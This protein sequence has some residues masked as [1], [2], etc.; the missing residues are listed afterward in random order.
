VAGESCSR[1]CKDGTTAL[2]PPTSGSLSQLLEK[3]TS[4]VRKRIQFFCRGPLKD[5]AQRRQR[6]ARRTIRRVYDKLHNLFVTAALGSSPSERYSYREPK[7]DHA[8]NGGVKRS[9]RPTSSAFGFGAGADYLGAVSHGSDSLR[10][11]PASWRSKSTGRNRKSGGS[12]CPTRQ[13]KVVE[14]QVGLPIKRDGEGSG[15]DSRQ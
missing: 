12:L 1:T 13:P 10:E 7:S 11:H 9:R 4:D 2:H 14:I 5:F 3:V 15:V 6:S 8:A